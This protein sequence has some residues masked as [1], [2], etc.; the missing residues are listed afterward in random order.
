MTRIDNFTIFRVYE[1]H[2]MT[3]MELRKSRN[4]SALDVANS[5]H[6]S[7]GYYSHLENGTRKLTGDLVKQVAY[8]LKVDE[9][10]IRESIG[11]NERWRTVS[12]NWISKIKINDKPAIK[13]FKEEAF[14]QRSN[15]DETLLL[16]FIKFVEFNIGNSIREELKKDPNAKEYLLK[17]LR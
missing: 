6:I 16:N 10:I 15:N 5:L 2:I 13:A 14:L 9:K 17:R 3:L 7:R 1:R 11:E 8:I 4:L 12:G